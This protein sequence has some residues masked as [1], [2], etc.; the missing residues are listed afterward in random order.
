MHDL[1]SG[2]QIAHSRLQ[3]SDVTHGRESFR[4]IGR[5][6]AFLAKLVESKEQ[7]SGKKTLLN[8][9][10]LTAYKIEHIAVG[11]NQKRCSSV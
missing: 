9:E 11:E 4:L 2:T 3:S 5:Q 1:Q 8:S 10:D 7:R 6:Q